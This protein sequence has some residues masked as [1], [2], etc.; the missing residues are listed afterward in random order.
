MRFDEVPPCPACGAPDPQ[1]LISPVSPR[2]K[3]GLR[4]AE[5][6]RSNATRQAREEQR[7]EQRAARRAPR[8]DG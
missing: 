5:A 6:R 7:R 4:G 8:G 2:L 3:F 1:R